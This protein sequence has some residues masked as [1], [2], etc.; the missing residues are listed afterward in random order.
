MFNPSPTDMQA[1]L[2]SAPSAIRQD[3][4]AWRV[5][6]WTSFAAAATLCGTGLAWLPGQDLA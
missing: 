4:Q 5:Q 1:H 3:T 6:V 2:T